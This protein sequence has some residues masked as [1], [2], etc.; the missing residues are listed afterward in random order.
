MRPPW[1]AHGL[2]AL[3]PLK[4]LE[5]KKVGTAVARLCASPGRGEGGSAD[6]SGSGSQV[7]LTLARRPG[8]PCGLTSCGLSYLRGQAFEERRFVT[9]AGADLYSRARPGGVESV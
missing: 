3:L 8:L 6:L 1:G 5:V 7:R 4:T 9:A 2:P